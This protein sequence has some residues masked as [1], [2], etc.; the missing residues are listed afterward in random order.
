MQV[1]GSGEDPEQDDASGADLDDLGNAGVGVVVAD[2]QLAPD[3]DVDTGGAIAEAAIVR[4][5][6]SNP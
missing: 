5:A 6:V 2:D 1:G 3:L 4:V